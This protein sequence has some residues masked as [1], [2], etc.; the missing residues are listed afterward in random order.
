MFI[1]LYLAIGFLSLMIIGLII[2]DKVDPRSIWF[3]INLF[4]SRIAL[5]L[6]LIFFYGF[7]ILLIIKHIQCN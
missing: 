7:I 5:I 6:F 1:L 3:P 2:S 4:T